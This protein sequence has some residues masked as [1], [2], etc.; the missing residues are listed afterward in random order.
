VP[1]TM[2][3]CQNCFESSLRHGYVV[4]GI[5]SLADFPCRIISA[6][7]PVLARGGRS[8][9]ASELFFSRFEMVLSLSYRCRVCA[10]ERPL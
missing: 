9:R 4:D 2:R 8:D 1:T 3:S 5:A 6:A 10:G 7:M